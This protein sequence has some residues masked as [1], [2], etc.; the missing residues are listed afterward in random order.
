LT[1]DVKTEELRAL[2]RNEGDEIPFE[3]L[4]INDTEYVD[5]SLAP[6]TESDEICEAL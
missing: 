6:L 3:E 1:E 4:M 5:A 2:A